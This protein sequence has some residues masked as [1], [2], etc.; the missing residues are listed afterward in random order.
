MSDVMHMMNG[1]RLSRPRI[2][3]LMSD[4][5]RMCRQYDTRI[6]YCIWLLIVL[7]MWCVF[8]PGVYSSSV[9]YTGVFE[10]EPSQNVTAMTRGEQR[11]YHRVLQCMLD[12]CEDSDDVMVLAPQVSVNGDPYRYRVIR[13]CAD[14][15][16]I[17]NPVV[18]VSGEN[19]GNCLDEYQGV[20]K[21]TERHYPITVR[22]GL[23][24]EMSFTLMTLDEVCPML[25]VLDILQG[26][27]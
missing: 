12:R 18:L 6:N 2:D 5:E 13:H 3:R 17:T 22:H 7:I 26:K 16:S 10:L 19:T 15:L 14:Q 9:E 20:S 23:S 4:L 24:G 8:M 11:V 27:W 21:Q 25:F 1:S